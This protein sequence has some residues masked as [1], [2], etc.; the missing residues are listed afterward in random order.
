MQA[1]ELIVTGD[2]KVIGELYT[3]NGPVATKAEVNAKA[4]AYSYGK[5]DL[6]AGSSY[7]PTGTLYF[8]YE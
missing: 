4:P 7:L 1:K 6:T 5:T 2:A 8:V 3:K